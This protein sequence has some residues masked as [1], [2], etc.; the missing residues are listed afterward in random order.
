MLVTP[1]KAYPI[2]SDFFLHKLF[3][4]SVAVNDNLKFSGTE[5]QRPLGHFP[6]NDFVA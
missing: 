5:I 2:H 1:R 6:L 3:K 4:A